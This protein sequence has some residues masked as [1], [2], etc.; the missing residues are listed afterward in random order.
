[1]RRRRLWAARR[2]GRAQ[3]EAPGAGRCRPG[4]HLRRCP[5]RGL[6]PPCRPP[7]PTSPP[8]I[9][10]GLHYLGLVIEELARTG[11]TLHYSNTVLTKAGWRWD[12]GRWLHT[13][14]GPAWRQSADSCRG[15][16]AE[17]AIA[18]A[19]VL[20]PHP[21]PPRPCRPAVQVLKPALGGSTNGL[22]GPCNTLMLGCISPLA[23]HAQRTRDTLEFLAK[24]SQRCWGGGKQRL[25]QRTC[26]PCHQRWRLPLHAASPPPCCHCSHLQAGTVKNSVSADV[27]AVRLAARAAEAQD[28]AAAQGEA[29]RLRGENAA[30]REQLTA[31]RSGGA[32]GE[33][34]GDACSGARGTVQLSQEQF[35]ELQRQLVELR[36]AVARERAR[37]DAQQELVR[38]M[39]HAPEQAAT[40]AGDTQAVAAAPSG[41]QQQQQ[42]AAGEPDAA[43]AA[44][45]PGATGQGT[46]IGGG[47]TAAGAMP[48]SAAGFTP[49]RRTS[50]F[51]AAAALAAM[52][53]TPVLSAA[54]AAAEAEAAPDRHSSLESVGRCGGNAALELAIELLD[55]EDICLSGASN[56][57]E[58]QLALL[59]GLV[60]RR[61]EAAAEAAVEA[62]AVP[63]PAAA[64]AAQLHVE[65]A[66]LRATLMRREA[67]AA[68]LGLAAR[69]YNEALGSALAEAAAAAEDLAAYRRVKEEEF[70]QLL[71]GE[72]GRARRWP[73]G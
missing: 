32:V 8:S 38:Q 36:S 71:S 68:A 17:V 54:E 40:P 7:S 44:A 5:S 9:N 53:A 2:N 47:A 30:L 31:L 28:L 19:H 52:Q 43:A 62:E 64:S 48:G 56:L 23:A 63:S 10:L 37:A 26:P 16:W 58:A 24:A 33:A 41:T 55:V 27:T 72:Q 50:I 25:L 51:N 35:E 73:S 21:I 59:E 60:V 61:L 3:G 20:A 42:G 29:E 39:M 1:M 67:E 69:T 46:P 65:V 12:R 13:R 14:P 66:H 34:G 6:Y 49:S 15:R 22:L 70:A 18:G 57:A 11:S 4:Q 45:A